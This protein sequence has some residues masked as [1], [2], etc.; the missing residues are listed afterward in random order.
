VVYLGT[1]KES[2]D[3][4]PFDKYANKIQYYLHIS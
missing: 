2:L 1:V 3:I 4:H